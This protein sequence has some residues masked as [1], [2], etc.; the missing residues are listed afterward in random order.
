MPTRKYCSNN[1]SKP[2]FVARITTNV[3]DPFVRS[4]VSGT[5]NGR[6]DGRRGFTWSEIS[7]Q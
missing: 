2:L 1:D 5:R 6:G 3:A 7:G 4:V